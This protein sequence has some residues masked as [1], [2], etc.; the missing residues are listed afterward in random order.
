MATHKIDTKT[1]RNKLAPR[2]EP[3]F[4]KMGKGL[5]LGYR[6]T[7]TGG[8]W[9]AR[10]TKTG[11]VKIYQALTDADDYDTATA[12]ATEWF[13]AAGTSTDH[14]YT[15]RRAMETYQRNL[16]TQGKTSRAK[17]TSVVVN[18]LDAYPVRLIDAKLTELTTP[19]LRDWRDSMVATSG[20]KEAVRKSKATANSYVKHVKAA[21]NL[22]HR[23]NMIASDRAWRLLETFKGVTAKVALLLT[24]EQVTRLVTAAKPAYGAVLKAAALTGC[25]NCELNESRVSDFDAKRGTLDVD[26]KTGERSVF[27]SQDAVAYLKTQAK[28]K[29]PGAYLFTQ[30]NGKPWDSNVQGMAM[31]ALRKRANLPANTTFYSLRHYHISMQLNQ[32]LPVLFIAQNNGTSVRMIEQTYGKFSDESR[33]DIAQRLSLAI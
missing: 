23:D 8:S 25:R 2:N 6:R 18:N 5:A 22:A 29:L 20:D 33:H 17:M 10:R 24:N 30:A 12:L 9:V 19:D 7:K 14:K 31:K 11:G 21:L 32:G 26:G 13:G 27:L 3:Y 1:A 16:E 28:N 15:L 4:V